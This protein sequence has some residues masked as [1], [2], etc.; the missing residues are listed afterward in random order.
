ML[1]WTQCKE[2][3]GNWCPSSA[4][5]PITKEPSPGQ[6]LALVN[7]LCSW[8][9]LR[10]PGATLPSKPGILL[11]NLVQI[12]WMQVRLGLCVP[13]VC[14]CPLFVWEMPSFWSGKLTR[15]FSG[16]T[17]GSHLSPFGKILCCEYVASSHLGFFQPV[18][19]SLILAVMT[20]IHGAEVTWI[21]TRNYESC[22]PVYPEA[23]QFGMIIFNILLYGHDYP[24]CEL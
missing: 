16:N 8:Q 20:G 3:G 17:D 15:L 5:S 24:L 11:H 18:F 7:L 21:C 14:T 12:W 23:A 1:F 4:W 6:L 22:H 10:T 2:E 9:K 13:S 19:L